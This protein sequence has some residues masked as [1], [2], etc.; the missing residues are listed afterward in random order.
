MNGRVA[1]IP[2]A[3]G[4][5]VMQGETLIVLEAMKMEHALAA[6]APGTVVAVHVSVNEQVGPGKLL[7]VI[8]PRAR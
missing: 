1:Q 3:V 4:A 2:I 6:R 5:Q 8:S 7:V